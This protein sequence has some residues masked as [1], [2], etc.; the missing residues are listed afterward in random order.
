[1]PGESRRK[2]FSIASGTL[3]AF[4]KMPLRTRLAATCIFVNVVK[5]IRSGVI[6]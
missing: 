4:R 5:D 2:D 6:P 1:M 3:L